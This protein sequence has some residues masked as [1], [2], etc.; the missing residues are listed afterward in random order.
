MEG[1][2]EPGFEMVDVSSTKVRLNMSG[3]IYDGSILLILVEPEKEPVA[4]DLVILGDIFND[5]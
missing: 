4:V 2:K 5:R 1:G 3:Y